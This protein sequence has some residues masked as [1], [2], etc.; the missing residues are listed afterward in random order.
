MI[1][2]SSHKLLRLIEN[3][4]EWA[5]SQTGTLKLVRTNLILKNL[6]EDV[7]KIYSTQAETKG[8]SLKNEIP[9]NIS[10][11]ADY[12]ILAVIIRN[13]ISNG[14]K[15]TQKGGNVS[16][17]ACKED[18]KTVLKISDSG[19]GMNHEVLEKLFKIEE[20]FTTAGT[21]NEAGTGLGLVI[22]KEFIETL[23]GT[24][25]VE[26][27]EGKGTTFSVTMPAVQN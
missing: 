20:T 9:D 7:L 13:L 11:F 15:Y 4:L 5:R 18:G 26:S 12:E 16:L 23:G 21:S 14:V 3:L 22:C 17:T 24:I 1:N 6:A 8:I 19:I 25:A 10:V 2:E 27:S